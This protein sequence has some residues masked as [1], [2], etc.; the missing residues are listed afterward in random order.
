[1]NLQGEEE[2]LWKYIFE[3]GTH[4]KARRMGQNI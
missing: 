4:I 2:T 1:M 3:G